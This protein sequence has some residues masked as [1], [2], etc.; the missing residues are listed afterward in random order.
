[1]V[2]GDVQSGKTSHYNGLITKAIDSG[3]K[4]IIVMSGIYNSL[5]AQTQKRIMENT[6]HSGDPGECN[7]IFFAT[8]TPKY[9]FKDAVKKYL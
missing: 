2:V 5:R 8:D 9:Y 4:L 6:I 3:Y 7:K 1:M